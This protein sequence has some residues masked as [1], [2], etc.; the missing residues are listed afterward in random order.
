M[1]L[2]RLQARDVFTY[3]GHAPGILELSRGALEAQVELLLLEPRS[4]S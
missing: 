4:S 3:L 2:K 1:A